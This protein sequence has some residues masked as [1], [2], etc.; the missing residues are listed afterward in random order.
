MRYL[1]PLLLTFILAGCGGGSAPVTGGGSGTTQ[2]SS[3]GTTTSTAT[4]GQLAAALPVGFAVGGT[5]INKLAPDVLKT[6]LEAA[7]PGSTLVTGDPTCAVSLY[8]ISYVTVGANGEPTT[9][10]AAVM[11]PSGADPSCSGPRPVLLYAH[12]TAVD[13]RYSMADLAGN[14][15]ARLVA[16]MFAAQ[17]YLVVAPNYTGYAG[18]KLGYHPYLHADGQG[19]DMVD[20]LRAARKAFGTIGA[21]PGSKLFISGYSQGGYVALAAQR[22][23]Q[24]YGGEFAVTAAGA[25]SGPYAL[26]QMG[27]NI[28]AGAPTLGVT[29]FMP[30]LTNGAQHAGA[31]LYAT[32]GEMYESPYAATIDSLLPGPRTLGELETANL[33]PAAAFFAPD[34]LPQA[35]GVAGSFGAGNLVRSSYRASYLADA[36][37]KPCGA[38]AGAPLA[39]APANA[40][41]RY[42]RANDLRQFVP[43]APTL[44]CGGDA[45]PTVPY[46][47]TQAMAGYL[48]AQAMKPELVE[49]NLD[50]IP[51]PG[52]S[53]RNAKLSFAAA[54]AALKLDG[55][56]AAV[57]SSYHAGLVAPF[58][59]RV[60]RDYFGSK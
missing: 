4:R 9:S 37:A 27:D 36:K 19:E 7:Q 5:T 58:C 10:A 13:T 14:M 35:G 53:Y 33:L 32:A 15:E 56:D 51:N 60:V 55:G 41:R 1:P 40:L 31:A 30:L 45:D 28:F 23:M 59:I 39:C 42:M 49:V 47:N 22:A 43:A 44:L 11:V 46:A 21:N 38:T 6:Y 16:A 25:M 29:A 50:T 2:T 57:T 52:D 8:A 18:S 3:G 26:L 54:K 48:R 34:S 17:G 20:A 24:R 12:G